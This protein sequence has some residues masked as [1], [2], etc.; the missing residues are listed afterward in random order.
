MI[1]IFCDGINQPLRSQLRREGP[2]SS[3]SSFLDF[4]LTVGS[5]FTVGVADEDR[6]TASRTEMVDAPE[7]VHKLA[8]AP[9]PAPSQEFAEV[10][11]RGC[12]DPGAR[13][14]CSRGR[15]DPGAH[16]GRSRGRSDPGAHRVRV[17]YVC[18]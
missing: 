5:P 6:D 11:S 18:Q 8:A 7:R 2:R 15:S 1:E 14:V 12:S 3:L 10:R 4:A 13:R 17:T 16:R 9:E